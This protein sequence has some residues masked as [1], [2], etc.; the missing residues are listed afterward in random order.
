MNPG[1]AKRK[2]WPVVA[3]LMVILLAAAMLLLPFPVKIQRQL[4]GVAFSGEPGEEMEPC[5]VAIEGTKYCYLLKPDVFDGTFAL[6]VDPRTTERGAHLNAGIAGETVSFL[7]YTYADETGGPGIAHVGYFLSDSDLNWVYVRTRDAQG[8]IRD[9]AA[10]AQ[11]RE[12]TLAVREKA[13]SRTPGK[14]LPEYS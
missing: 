3:A 6:S 5:E 9:I 12:E 1:K 4:T 2:K 11:G 7:T 8:N 14:V 13:A 10:P